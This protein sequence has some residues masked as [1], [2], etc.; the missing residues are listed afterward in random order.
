MILTETL[1]SCIVKITY[2]RKKNKFFLKGGLTFIFSC[3]I[4][5]IRV[6]NPNRPIRAVSSYRLLCDV[7]PAIK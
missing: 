3:N 6:R 7:K 2:L 1:Y 5:L 4:L